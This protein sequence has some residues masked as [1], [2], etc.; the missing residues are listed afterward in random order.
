[1]T[2][3]QSVVTMHT[4][5]LLI[6]RLTKQTKDWMQSF[7]PKSAKHQI[8]KVYSTTIYFQGLL[9]KQFPDHVNSERF[10]EKV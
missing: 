2:F 3:T 4:V 1:M 5:S 9:S 7:R 10:L 6:I 8:A